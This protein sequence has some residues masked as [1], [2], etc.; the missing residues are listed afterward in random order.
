MGGNRRIAQ[1]GH[2]KQRERTCSGL[3]LVASIDVVLQQ[4]RNSVQGAEY[5][6]MSAQHVGMTRHIQG[7][8]VQFDNRIDSRTIL[9]V[10]D[11]ALD[12]LLG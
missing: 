9:V 11:D 6:A 7:V 2:A 1:R 8:G 4:D 12:V 5:R 3:H 10:R